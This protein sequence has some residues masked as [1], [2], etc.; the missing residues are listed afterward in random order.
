MEAGVL[1]ME[2]GVLSMEVGC[3]IPTHEVKAV[4]GQASFDTKRLKKL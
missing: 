4:A 3:G 2:A 1:S